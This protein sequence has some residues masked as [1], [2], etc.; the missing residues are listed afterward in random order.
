[1]SA[2]LLYH[3]RVFQ[4]VV[5]RNEGVVVEAV[6]HPKTEDLSPPRVSHLLLEAS[7]EVK[8]APAV[9]AVDH[10]VRVEHA[11]ALHGLDLAQE[12]LDDD[13]LAVDEVAASETE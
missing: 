12:V 1:M 4:L 2:H 10:D 3:L 5:P 7:L 6:S 8:D 9:L 11:Q 13:E